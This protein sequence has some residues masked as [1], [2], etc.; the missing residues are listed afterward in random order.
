MKKAILGYGS[1]LLACLFL[2]WWLIFYSPLNLPDKIPKT[3]ISINGLLLLGLIL[4]ILIIAEKRVLKINHDLNILQL[5]L[6]GTAICFFAELIFQAL[7]QPF[8][9]ADNFSEHLYFYMMGTVGTSVFALAIAFL[10]AFQL[11]TKK[12]GQLLLL[13]VGL[14]IIINIVRYL[15]PTFA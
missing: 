14:I 9:K 13:I 8:L 15:F 4:T 2:E 12:T 5:T 1:I 11:K 10:V 6:F 3:P 7:R